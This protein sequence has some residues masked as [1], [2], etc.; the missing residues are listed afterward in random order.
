MFNKKI[1]NKTELRDEINSILNNHSLRNSLLESQLIISFSA[2]R[3]NY[4]D[5]KFDEIDIKEIGKII[6]ER[7]S[8]ALPVADYFISVFESTISWALL[9]N[10]IPIF[11]DYYQLNFDL[12]KFNSCQI[13]KEKKQFNEDLQRIVDNRKTLSIHL[14]KDNARLPPFDGKSGKRIFNEIIKPINEK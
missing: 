4:L 14:Q 11:L 2:K 12:K 9:C 13:L 7:L 5:V 6:E 3:L 1:Q 8:E 10:V